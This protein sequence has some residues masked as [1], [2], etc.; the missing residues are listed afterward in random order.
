MINISV[1]YP[2]GTEST[3]QAGDTKIFVAT[4]LSGE[5]SVKEKGLRVFAD[6]VE[7]VFAEP[8]AVLE[9]AAPVKRSK[10]A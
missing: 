6:G 10:K 8:E 5:A 3:F 1:L 2:D 9:E 7:Y 4:V